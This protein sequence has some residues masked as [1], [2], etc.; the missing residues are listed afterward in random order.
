MVADR[1]LT[2]VMLSR[3]IGRQADPYAQGSAAY[4][5]NA[6]IRDPQLAARLVEDW[7]NDALTAWSRQ[8]GSVPT[9]PP[10]REL[11]E[12]KPVKDGYTFNGWANAFGRKIIDNMVPDYGGRLTAIWT[13]DVTAS[14]MPDDD[15]TPVKNGLEPGDILPVLAPVGGK[16]FAGWYDQQGSPVDRIPSTGGM[17][18]PMWVSDVVFDLQG[19]RWPDGTPTER[20]AMAIVRRVSCEK[21]L[22]DAL[23]VSVN[24]IR[25]ASLY[26]KRLAGRRLPR[27]ERQQVWDE[28]VWEEISRQE[29]VWAAG[30]RG[31][32]RHLPLA[33]GTSTSPV[34]PT[35][36]ACGG[37]DEWERLCHPDHGMVYLEDPQILSD[38]TDTIT[39]VLDA[40]N[41]FDAAWF[42][43]HGVT[44]E[45]LD[46]FDDEALETLGLDPK[47]VRQACLQASLT[48]RAAKISLVLHDPRLAV[49]ADGLVKRGRGADAVLATLGLG[50]KMSRTG[51]LFER[52][53]GEHP[54]AEEQTLWD[55]ACDQQNRMKAPRGAQP[56]AAGL[57]AYRLAVKALKQRLAEQAI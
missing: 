3:I 17:V 39:Q 44:P 46:G 34:N 19:G 28:A 40:D 47:A 11:P 50:V 26:E 54:K 38:Q 52:L 20:E 56:G 16:P 12:R 31:R 49:L 48:G 37:L 25:A 10:G 43:E 7:I 51:L 15:E 30:G 5:V 41:T 2:P 23:G 57:K 21:I 4:K 18:T 32:I 36:L 1:D 6:L 55:W 22:H 29:T 8:H 42:R 53:R 27:E 45:M 9:P 33:D 24:L 14:D 13:A 35:R